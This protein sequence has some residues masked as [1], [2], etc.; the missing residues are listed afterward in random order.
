MASSIIKNTELLAKT[1]YGK[2]LKDLSSHELHMC[3]GKAV[4]AEISENWQKSR[5]AHAS[6]RR[7]YYLSAEFLMGRMIYNNHLRSADRSR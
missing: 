2:N 7:A 1:E 4:T 6:S 3:I 5:D